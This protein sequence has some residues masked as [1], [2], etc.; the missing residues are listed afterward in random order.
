MKKIITFALILTSLSIISC[1]KETAQ[2]VVSTSTATSTN[3]ESINVQYRVTSASGFF[4]VEYTSLEND[5]VTTTNIDVNEVAFTY[6]FTWT[7][8]QRLSIKAFN[9]TPSPKEILVEIYVN[10]VLFKS[11]LANTPGAIASAEGVYYK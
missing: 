9:S 8:K 10:G 5:K 3:P 1:K 4:N 11:G 7:K 6:S 2:P